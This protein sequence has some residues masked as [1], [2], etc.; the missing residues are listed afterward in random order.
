MKVIARALSKPVHRAAVAIPLLAAVT[1][2]APASAT[3]IERVMSAS[4]VEAWLVHEPAV[5]LISIDFASEIDLLLTDVVM[6]GMSGPHLVDEIAAIQP[7]MKVL[8]MSGYPEPA[9]EGGETLEAEQPL[10][11]KPFKQ[12]ELARMIREVLEHSQVG[13]AK[14]E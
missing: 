11:R 10:L 7:G 2:A 9:Y 1:F 3:T 12:P 14:A 13:D 5:P 4:G 6:P 8:F